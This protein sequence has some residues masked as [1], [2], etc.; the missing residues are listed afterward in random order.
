MREF[1]YRVATDKINNPFLIILKAII[2]LLSFL[3]RLAVK[4]ILWCYKVGFFKKYSLPK[5]V[6]SIG[7]MT[8]G[9]VGKTPMVA[10]VAQFLKEKNIKPVVLTRGYMGGKNN[11]S[12][13][14]RFLS[15]SLSGIPVA[16][17][18]NRYQKGMKAMEKYH[19]DI[20]LLDDG[21]QHWRL[22][23]DL[24]IV[25]IDATNP[26]GNNQL[27]PRGILREPLSSLP[28]ADIFVLTK[29]DFA[30]DNLAALEKRL[31]AVNPRALMV[32]AVHQPVNLL[33]LKGTN[34]V[35]NLSF[36][37]GKRIA[38]VSAIGDPASFERSLVQLGAEVKK[39]CIFMDHHVYSSEDIQAVAD[40]C[41]DNGIAAVLTTEKDAVKLNELKV[42]TGNN[43]S[44]LALK[45]K[46]EIV[47]GKNEFF[48][49]I[50][51]LSNR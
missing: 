17:G 28:R 5:P 6:I 1:L 27:I 30:K 15:E 9:G 49:R 25:V 44:L 12:D 2:L 13:E 3:Y 21:F 50:S 7:N 8:L 22:R 38:A 23:R 14:A 36:L 45:I 33:D 29:T 40:F 4:I 26:F 18:P 37:K 31:M 46:I 42:L 11:E 10:L 35:H 16:V 48:S 51:R 34:I 39:H 19:P 41:H 24:D 47:K 43:V 32:E 20:F